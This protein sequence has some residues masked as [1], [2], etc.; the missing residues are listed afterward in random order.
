MQSKNL[1]QLAGMLE[2]IKPKERC[3][4]EPPRK[5]KD[6]GL[7]AKSV[8]DDAENEVEEDEDDS[9][10]YDSHGRFLCVCLVG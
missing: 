3:D 7:G 8:R 5:M 1:K 9:R 2:A 10:Y 4:K 6:G